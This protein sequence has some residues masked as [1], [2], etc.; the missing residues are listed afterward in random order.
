MLYVGS[1]NDLSR[2]L[3]EHK[4]KLAEGYTKKYNISKLV[5]FESYNSREDS[6]KRERQ[7]EGWLRKRK[8]G[9]I[10][11]L[12]PTWKDLSFRF[13]YPE[14]KAKELLRVFK[15]REFDGVQIAERLYKG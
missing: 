1:T 12:N 4:L 13:I 11:T 3:F 10:E 9:L 15:N 5:Y 7:L 6:E 8:I 2:R 14:S